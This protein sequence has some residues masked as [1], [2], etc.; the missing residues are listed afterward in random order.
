MPQ[1]GN[2]VVGST[3]SYFRLPSCLEQGN[4]LAIGEIARPLTTYG[5]IRQVRRCG[6]TASRT[7]SSHTQIIFASCDD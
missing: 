3:G 7:G 1:S 5:L 6:G 4:G 2:I